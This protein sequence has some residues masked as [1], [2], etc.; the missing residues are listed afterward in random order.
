MGVDP[1]DVQLKL[2]DDPTPQSLRTLDPSLGFA[3]GTWQGAEEPWEQGTIRLE[4]GA[5]HRPSVASVCASGIVPS[6]GPHA[7]NCLS[8]YCRMPPC[9]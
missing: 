5:I 7:S 6:L 8:T 3:A 4:R 1:D 2:F 9:R